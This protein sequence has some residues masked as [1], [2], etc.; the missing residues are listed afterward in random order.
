MGVRVSVRGAGTGAGRR[1]GG[2]DQGRRSPTP[3]APAE[4]R[5][6]PYVITLGDAVHNF[7]DGLAVGA[8]FLSSWKTGLATSLAVFCHEVPHEL[9]EPCGVPAGRGAVPAHIGGLGVA[10]PPRSWARLSGSGR[11]PLPN[12]SPTRA[13]WLRQ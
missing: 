6:L 4:L 12:P 11:G 9:G 5:L 1:G 2:A 13:S 3:A 10:G 8:A 7:A